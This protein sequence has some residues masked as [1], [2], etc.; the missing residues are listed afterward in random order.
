M[1]ECL[2]IKYRKRKASNGSDT[3]VTMGNYR[4]TRYA[5]DFV[6]FAKS[7]EDIEQVPYLLEPYLNERGLIL[8]EDKTRITHVSEGFNF[9]GFE[10]RQQKS[11]KKQC[12]IKP[13]KESIKSAKRKLSD[14]YKR[15]NGHNV[16]EL[17]STVNPILDGIGNYWKPM[18]A[19]YAFAKVD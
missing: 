4:M 1:E 15:M 16:G 2:G 6:I 5:D 10:T 19:S 7:K 9:L 18:V 8:A 14:T 11:G 17:I 13:S 12:N 3:F